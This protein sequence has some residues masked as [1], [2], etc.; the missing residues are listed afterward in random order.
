MTKPPFVPIINCDP[1]LHNGNSFY[2][3]KTQSVSEEGGIEIG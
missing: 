2:R 3:L 1:F